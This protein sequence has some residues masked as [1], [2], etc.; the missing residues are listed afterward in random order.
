MLDQEF[1]HPSDSDWDEPNNVSV[2]DIDDDDED[3]LPPPNKISRGY[4]APIV[5]PDSP[6]A[7]TEA[8]VKHPEKTEEERKPPRRLPLSS[9]PR[10]N[11]FGKEPRTVLLREIFRQKKEEFEFVEV[12]F[13]D[14]Y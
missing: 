12:G 7:K 2:I 1:S 8:K 11:M 13:R 5:I 9:D 10:Y 3:V 4:T 6:K 14:H